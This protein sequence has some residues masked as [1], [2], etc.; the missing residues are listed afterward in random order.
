MN[1]HNVQM[2]CH[3]NSIAKKIR[4]ILQIHR[5]FICDGNAMIT[6]EFK[7]GQGRCI[8]KGQGHAKVTTKTYVT[9]YSQPV[10]CPVL[11][12]VFFFVIKLRNKLLLCCGTTLFTYACEEKNR[13]VPSS[14]THRESDRTCL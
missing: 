11:F 6:T 14:I 9:N 8:A 13:Y 12:S 2:T 10:L 1:S 5:L 7:Q 4:A 3:L